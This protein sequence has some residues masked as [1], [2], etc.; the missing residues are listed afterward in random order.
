MKI[1]TQKVAEKEYDIFVK[2]F[3][4]YLRE[5]DPEFEKKKHLIDKYCKLIIID[6][7][8]SVNWIIYDD[9]IAGFVIWYLYDIYEGKKGL[10]ISE[11]YILKEYRRKKIGTIALENILSKFDLEEIRLEAV[12][13]NKV[14]VSFWEKLGFKVYKFIMKKTRE[15]L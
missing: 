1:K 3:Y 11:Y 12:V 7:K 15:F 5:I 6:S 13:Q 2:F 10:H 9:A 4:E 14:A 8:Y